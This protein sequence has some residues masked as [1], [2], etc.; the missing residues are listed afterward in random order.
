[1]GNLASICK[2]E[3]SRDAECDNLAKGVQTRAG[4]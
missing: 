2:S 4:R 1:M 3:I